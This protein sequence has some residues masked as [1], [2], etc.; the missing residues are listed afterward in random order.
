MNK[1]LSAGFARLWKNKFFW[2]G[3]LLMSG[4][5]VLILLSNYNYMRKHAIA[6]YTLDTF[7]PTCMMFIGCFTAV[8]AAMFLGTEYSDGAIR[9]KLIAGHS[10]VCV[11]LSSLLLCAAASLLVC[12]ICVAV[13]F[14]VGVP[15]FGMPADFS[16]LLQKL[17]VGILLVVSFSSLFTFPSMLLHNKALL[18]VTCVMS[19]FVLLFLSIYLNTRL[20]EP[21][22]VE[23][24]YSLFVDGEIVQE[25]PVPNPSYLRGAKR[26]A[27]EFF[28]DFLPTGQSLSFLQLKLAH[29]WRM[30]ILSLTLALTF[31]LGGVGLFRRKDL[32]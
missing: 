16:A 12:A 32:N 2:A 31:T 30:S 15:L 24:P 9:N 21:E 1:L 28:Q 20:D 3:V 18:A 7:L 25:E 22:Y 29:P 6:H 8:F 14:A 27:F 13:T 26:A 10:R 5:I 4:L 19:F 11:Y 23:K 17:G